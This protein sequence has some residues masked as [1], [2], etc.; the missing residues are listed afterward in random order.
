M[1]VDAE[2]FNGGSS[3][4]SIVVQP[5]GQGDGVNTTAAHATPLAIY[6]QNGA[7]SLT[8]NTLIKREDE[9]L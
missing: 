9:K 1:Q 5:R 4:N 8:N 6:Q 7:K 3:G 2:D